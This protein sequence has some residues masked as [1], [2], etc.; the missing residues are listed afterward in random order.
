MGE[1]GKVLILALP[2]KDESLSDTVLSSVFLNSMLIASYCVS[3]TDGEML[4][5]VLG[6][7][8]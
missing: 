8:G 4:L 5:G 2:S 7:T 3:F 1:A 6:A